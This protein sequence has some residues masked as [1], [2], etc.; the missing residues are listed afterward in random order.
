MT[1]LIPFALFIGGGL[2]V[3]GQGASDDPRSKI[4]GPEW[5]ATKSVDKLGVEQRGFTRPLVGQA[6]RREQG[7]A[8]LH[9]VRL[10]NGGILSAQERDDKTAVTVTLSDRKEGDERVRFEGHSDGKGAATR[11]AVQFGPVNYIDLD[12]DGV[13]DCWVDTRGAR[14]RS[15]IVF[16]D[17]LVEVE[18]TLNP[19]A[20]VGGLPPAAWASGRAVR[21]EF[22]AGR[23]SAVKKE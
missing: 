13:I 20:P 8:T 10:E 11:H 9:N 5:T 1:R 23:W 22:A 19:F 14:R 21:Y 12:G 15:V 4:L 18:D 6:Y 17:R 3:A 16:E 2:V 7:D